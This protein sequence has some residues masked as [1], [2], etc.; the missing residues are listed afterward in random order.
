MLRKVTDACLAEL[1]SLGDAVQNTPA[2]DLVPPAT[3]VGLTALLLAAVAE[4]VGVVVEL[5][6]GA[7][8]D[9][10][11]RTGIPHLLS[12]IDDQRLAARA[13]KYSGA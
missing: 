4:E 3:A 10:A 1:A 2:D 11:V 8:L 9:A 13:L 5:P 12:V 7:S 6:D